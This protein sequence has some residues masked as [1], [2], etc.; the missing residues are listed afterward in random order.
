[1]KENKPDLPF[2]HMKGKKYKA[3]QHRYRPETSEIY[4]NRYGFNEVNY[5]F[6]ALDAYQSFP[7]TLSVTG[8]LGE[9]REVILR[10]RYAKEIEKITDVSENIWSRIG[11]AVHAMRESTRSTVG[12]GIKLEK[13]FRVELTEYLEGQ[14]M[15]CDDLL[16]L[17][18]QVD[19]YFPEKGMIDDFKVTTLHTLVMGYRN[20]EWLLQISLYAFLLQHP[21]HQVFLKNGT[22]KPIKKCYPVNECSVSCLLRDYQK[23]HKLKLPPIGRFP[24]GNWKHKDLVSLQLPEIS[25]PPLPFQKVEGWLKM[26]LRNIVKYWA[27]DDDDLPRCVERWYRDIKCKDYC[28]ARHFCCFGRKKEKGEI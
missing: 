2:F 1:M 8:I 20:R 16:W 19:S 27:Y 9:A 3:N 15:P 26:K 5:H 18:G 23:N 14:G 11:Q 13:R 17:T 4:L 7:S 25:F 22:W 6:L 12:S 10:F 24:G 28:Q 21:R